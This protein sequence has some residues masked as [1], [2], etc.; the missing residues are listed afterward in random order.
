MIRNSTG[1]AGIASTEY[2]MSFPS[3]RAFVRPAPNSLRLSGPVFAVFRVTACHRE[4]KDS[5]DLSA[6]RTSRPDSIRW[7]P[8]SHHRCK[9]WDPLS[10]P[11]ARRLF[12]IDA[13]PLFSRASRDGWRSL[14]LRFHV[15]HAW[16]CGLASVIPARR[17]ARSVLVQRPS[18]RNFLVVVRSGSSRGVSPPGS[19]GAMSKSRERNLWR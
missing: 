6:R 1:R 8:P 3:K 9:R 7:T 16:R 18:D 4:R 13:Y 2:R 10:N 11:L 14:I 19:F 5:S 17:I 15:R 12:L